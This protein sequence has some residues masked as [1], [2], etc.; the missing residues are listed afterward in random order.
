M[1][2]FSSN[3]SFLTHFLYHMSFVLCSPQM[4]MDSEKHMIYTFGGR[5]LTCN[6][7]VEDSR[8]S[9]PQFSGLYAYHC[10]AGTWSLLREDSCNAGPED[11]QSRIGHCMLFHTVSPVC[12]KTHSGL[13][14]SDNPAGSDYQ[15][16]S[17]PHCIYCLFQQRNRYLYVFGGQ[18]SKTYLNDFFSYDVDGDHVEIISDGTKKDSGMGMNNSPRGLITLCVCHS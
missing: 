7:S 4:C 17:P 6:G 14:L 13:W 2:P 8:T 16:L 11:V 18:R 9:E 15:T 12:V 10:Q 3:L 5:I 1:L